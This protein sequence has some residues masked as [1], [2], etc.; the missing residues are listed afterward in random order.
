MKISDGAFKHVESELY[1]FHENRRELQKLRS[2]IM[3][4]KISGDENIGGG[5]SNLPGDPTGRVATMLAANKRLIMLD[6]TVSAIEST[7]RRLNAQP[8][9]LVELRYWA[10]P[11]SM[12]WDD[13]AK[14]VGISRRT[15]IRWRDAIV[16]EIA[17]SLG[18]K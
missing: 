2:Q 5:K 1:S 15:A 18:W 16:K 6:Q 9:E 8:K 10:E 4:E 13:I 12:T 17:I 14:K 11:Q 3:F 7:L